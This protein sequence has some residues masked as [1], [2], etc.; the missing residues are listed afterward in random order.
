MGAAMILAGCS[1]M[2]VRSASLPGDAAVQTATQTVVNSTPLP[3]DSPTP[4]ADTPTASPTPGLTY[5]SDD[6]IQNGVGRLASNFLH[7][8]RNPGLSVAVIRRNP[9][10]GELEALLLN[11]GTAARDGGGPV[12]SNTIYEIGSITKVFT[13]ILLAEAVND[14]KMKLD[15]PIQGYLPGGVYAPDYK[16]IPITLNELATHRSGLPRDLNSDSLSDLYAWLNGFRLSRAPGAEY[17]YSNLGYSLLGD[18]LARNANADYGTLVFQS[19]SQ[20]L[21]LMDTADALSAEQM[22]RLAQGYAYDGSLARYFPDSGAMAPAGY[23]HSTL[24]DLTRFVIDN[25]QPDSTPLAAA[26]SLAQT[27]QS[28]GSNP[29]TGTALGWEIDRLGK[30]DERIWKGGGTPGFTSYVSF[31]KDGSSGFVLLSN[32]QFI[33]NLVP[34][35][36]RLLHDAN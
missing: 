22:S 19:V 16:G 9:Q 17:V 4:L 34:D 23:L 27:S 5:F 7:Q 31:N 21:G 8:T 3:T 30:P 26:L 11:Y 32:G 18:I 36:I 35:M 24:N 12:N 2:S 29:G 15:D 28:E 25:M 6:D 13:G 14:G 20:P 10:S 33:D 1:P